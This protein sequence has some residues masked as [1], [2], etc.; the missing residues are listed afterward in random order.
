[1]WLISHNTAKDVTLHCRRNDQGINML[2]G[3]EI[4]G[5]TYDLTVNN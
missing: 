3:F 5:H 2:V 1:M 4:D